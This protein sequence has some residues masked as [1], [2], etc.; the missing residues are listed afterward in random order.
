MSLRILSARYNSNL[1]QNPYNRVMRYTLPILPAVA[2]L[3][4][5]ETLAWPQSTPGSTDQGRQGDRL[6]AA[7][8]RTLQE[9]PSL[10]ARVRQ[11]A[12]LFG[13]HVT[14]V[15]TYLQLRDG[16]RILLRY[17]FKLQLADQSHTL[18]HI[19]DGD[20]LWIRR[21]AGGS[22]SQSLVELRRLR[23]A[24]RPAP[25][26]PGDRRGL[27]APDLA[28][29]GL[30][31][32]LRNLAEN[33]EFRA[34]RPAELKG[35]PTWE[36]EGKWRADRSLRL[37]ANQESRTRAGPST[38]GE[39]L[40]EHLPDTVQLTL[41]RDQVFPLLP[42]RIEYQRTKRRQGVARVTSTDDYQVVP[43]VTLELYEVR[44]RPDLVPADFAW[45]AG[46][47]GVDDVT[48]SYLRRLGLVE[49]EKQSRGVGAA[50]FPFRR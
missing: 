8:W 39:Q 24:R 7:S 29:G 25:E 34:P 13:Q 50:L 38:D 35:V 45:Q 21:D 2:C 31:Y 20:K 11:R 43:L 12:A 44:R 46:S 33:F 47:D 16:E 23:D 37:L 10:E 48:D 18:L 19:N 26:A 49:A 40:A 3:V 6:V 41:G 36:V 17:E 32:L 30:G 4:L 42:Y 1:W 5:A 28:L 9:Q 22:A 14:G 27:A 15:G